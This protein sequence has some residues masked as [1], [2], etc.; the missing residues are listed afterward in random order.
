MKTQNHNQCPRC[1]YQYDVTYVVIMIEDCP[2]CGYHTQRRAHMPPARGILE[3]ITSLVTLAIENT[4]NLSHL[5]RVLTQQ[6][7]R[8]QRQEARQRNSNHGGPPPR[9]E[10]WP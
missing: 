9:E 3:M 4:T 7:A 5:H 6:A 1:R 8:V 10:E 2:N